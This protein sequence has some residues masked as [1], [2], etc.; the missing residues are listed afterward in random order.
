MQGQSTQL[1]FSGQ[2]IFVGIDVHLKSW[3]VTLLTEKLTHKTFTQPPK[4]EVLK[5]Y[6]ETNFP[7]GEY[8]SVYEAG[9]SGLWSHYKLTEMGINNIV[10]NPADVPTTQKEHLQKDDPTD[11]RKL[12]RSLRSGELHSIYIPESSTLEDRS[13]VRM[14]ASLVKD[15]IRFKQRIKSFL[16]FYGITYPPELMNQQTHWSKRFMNWLKEDVKLEH[17]SGN[18]T[19]KSLVQQAEQQRQLLLEL[20]RKIKELSRSEK[21]ATN[22]TLLRTIPGVGL[23]TAI[24]FLTEIENIERFRNTDHFA[25]FIGIVPNRHSSGGR[26]NNTEM[27]FRGQNMLRSY[28]IESSWIAAR[29]DPALTMSFHSY[30]KRMEP[31]KAIV[32]IARKL[33]NRIYSVL[34]NKSEYVP[35]IIK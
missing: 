12:A 21:Y 7:G 24:T 35:C 32:R 10:V 3:T 25:G 16:N 34:C 19:L 27:T 5:N 20:T 18:L 28:L 13:L 6:L 8:H 30:T 22:M 15:M 9:F 26:E 23:I 29:T 31:N 33:L 1:N 11:S 2:K 14:R 17:E 4:V